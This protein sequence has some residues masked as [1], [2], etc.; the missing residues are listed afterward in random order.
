MKKVSILV[1]LLAVLSGCAEKEDVASA[2]TAVPLS[3]KSGNTASP[4]RKCARAAF[5][6][7]YILSR[8]AMI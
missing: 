3:S 7:K 6:A 4:S 5:G 1:L 2:L 8:T